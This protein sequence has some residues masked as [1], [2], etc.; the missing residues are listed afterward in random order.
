MVSVIVDG[1]RAFNVGDGG[2][3]KRICDGVL[4]EDCERGSVGL[5][6]VWGCMG[7]D[8]PRGCR[9]GRENKSWMEDDEGWRE[10][11]AP[12]ECDEKEEEEEVDDKDKDELR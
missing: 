6:G 8:A 12:E 5:L 4:S 3:T 2:N 7:W 9:W 1:V 11:G 10:W